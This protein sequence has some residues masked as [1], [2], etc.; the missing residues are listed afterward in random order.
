M[1]WGI[2]LL[3]LIL[4]VAAPAPRVARAQPP[5]AP[6]Q[7]LEAILA[8]K[9]RAMQ[10]ALELEARLEA[11]RSSQNQAAR[12]LERERLRSLQTSQKRL[13][14]QAQLDR[15]R[16]KPL[17]RRPWFWGGRFCRQQGVP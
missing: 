11:T 2:T 14:T 5:A 7:A 6:V 17:Y 8:T 13:Q 4:W 15:E 16:N 3:L 1:R 9:A 10:V 12:E